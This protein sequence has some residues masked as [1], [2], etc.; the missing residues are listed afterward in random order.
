[1]RPSVTVQWDTKPLARLSFDVGRTIGFSRLQQNLC[2]ILHL[3]CMNWQIPFE[4]SE[5]DWGVVMLKALQT[6]Q[7]TS[8][9]RKNSVPSKVK[10][11]PKT[12]PP[13]NTLKNSQFTNCASKCFCIVQ[14]DLS[15]SPMS[16]LN[17]YEITRKTRWPQLR[18]WQEIER[19][20]GVTNLSLWSKRLGWGPPKQMCHWAVRWET[21]ELQRAVTETRDCSCSP[22]SL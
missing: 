16:N 13:T 10:E 15:H 11:N 4:T 20:K 14:W 22:L 6:H 19:G 18:Y 7:V 5:V 1:M 8:A 3:F 17:E 21:A 9:E 12:S 2:S